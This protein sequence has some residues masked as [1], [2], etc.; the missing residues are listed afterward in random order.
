[1]LTYNSSLDALM[2]VFTC[3]VVI[4]WGE[5]V[6]NLGIVYLI[7]SGITRVIYTHNMY[8]CRFN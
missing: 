3:L 1:M 5:R 4:N 6:Q 7:A 8:M 2:G